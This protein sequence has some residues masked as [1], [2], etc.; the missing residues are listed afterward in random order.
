M[1]CIAQRINDDWSGISQVRFVSKLSE[2]D[3]VA[4]V[5]EPLQVYVVALPPNQLLPCQQVRIISELAILI[6]CLLRRLRVT[7]CN[8]A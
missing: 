7:F 8:M 1:Y 3:D 2:L 6:H 4:P 5:I